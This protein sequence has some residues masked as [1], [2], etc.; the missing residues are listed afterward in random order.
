MRSKRK[1]NILVSLMYLTLQISF[2][3]KLS[4]ESELYHS[5]LYSSC[6]FVANNPHISIG[7][8]DEINQ[9][10][11]VIRFNDFWKKKCDH[12]PCVDILGNKTTDNVMNGQKMLEL[13]KLQQLPWDKCHFRTDNWMINW[14]ANKAKFYSTEDLKKFGCPIMSEDFFDDAIRQIRV[15]GNFNETTSISPTT[16]FLGVLL[17]SPICTGQVTFYGFSDSQMIP[18]WGPHKYHTEHRILR[19]M[20]PNALWWV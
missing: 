11:R 16:G 17:F 12:G 7:Y 1:R 3:L 20:H 4:E 13:E 10:D 19:S 15:E 5:R 14:K 18:F 2:L 6:A 9:H 8:A